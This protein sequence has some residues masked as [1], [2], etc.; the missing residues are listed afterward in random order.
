MSGVEIKHYGMFYKN[1]DSHIHKKN[2]KKLSKRHIFKRVDFE[3][4]KYTDDNQLLSSLLKYLQI[5]RRNHP[6]ACGVIFDTNIIMHDITYVPSFPDKFDI[7]C[8]ESELKSYKTTSTNNDSLYWTPTTILHSGNFLING[9]SIDKIMDIIKSV[10]NLNE[11]F[12]KVNDLN[13]FSITQTRFS[14][15]VNNYIHDPLVINKKLTEEDI[16]KY[17][18]K[19]SNEFYDKFQSMNLSV[20]TLKNTH[21]KDELLP[22]ISLICPFTDKNKFFHTLLSFLRLN[23]PR[24]LL[25]LV[26]V[27]DTNSEKELNLPEDSRIKLIN[28]TNSKEPGVALPIGYK[29]NVGVKHS[30]NDLI[31]H[32]FD[33]NNYSLNLRQLVSH[34]LLSNRQCVMSKDTGLYTKDTELYTKDSYYT[35]LPDLANC[36]YTR[37]FWKKASFEEVSHKLF[38]NCDL[39]HKWISFR[40]SEISFLP[41]PYMSF[42]M[43]QTTDEVYV[44]ITS[45]SLDLS[46]IIDKKIKESFEL[47][48]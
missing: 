14:E 7:L 22:K 48:L 36:L 35:S 11:F 16:K 26:I 41:F 19:L 43:K 42:K 6:S 2:K 17:N 20:D 1:D 30:S 44:P 24:H 13:V 3:L 23:Y 32:F 21:L 12:E 34:F 5:V 33:T 29:L 31:F 18:K 45:C 39:M 47:L 4:L 28:L 40:T 25:E 38:I 27:D 9:T 46:L 10:K 15:K 8:L 37:D